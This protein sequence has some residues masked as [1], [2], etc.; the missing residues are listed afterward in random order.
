MALMVDTAAEIL[1]FATFDVAGLTFGVELKRVQELIRYQD[2]TDVP[3]ASP[4]ISGLI[5]LRGQIVIA[6]DARRA[7]GLPDRSPQELPMN[8]VLRSDDGCV[9]LLVDRIGDVVAVSSDRWA[10][11]PDNMPVPKKKLIRGIYE[12]PGSLL[13]IPDLEQILQVSEE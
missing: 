3:L 4:S 10:S 2:M 5:N 13:L 9:S 7:L 11:V 1:H 12:F 6:I 8:V